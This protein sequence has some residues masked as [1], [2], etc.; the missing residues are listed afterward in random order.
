MGYSLSMTDG[1]LHRIARVEPRP[2][3][4]LLVDW[5]SG[6]QSVVDFAGDIANGGIWARLRDEEKFAQARVANEGRVLEWPD[7]AGRDGSPR[8]DVDADGLF[9]LATQQG[10]Q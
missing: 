7:P 8:I 10:A 4:R 9:D 3:H 6:D 5:A 1:I 2:G